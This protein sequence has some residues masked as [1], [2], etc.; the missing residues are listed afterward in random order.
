MH[1]VLERVRGAARER[2]PDAE[3]EPGVLAARVRAALACLEG[4][5]VEARCAADL[6]PA[7]RGLIDG[8]A[9]V[10]VAEDGTGALVIATTDGAV[11]V[12]A[13]LAGLFE[14]RWP[15]LAIDVAR[16]LEEAP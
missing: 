13:S 12:D 2:L 14:R 10:R 3:L 1:A 8:R 7:V 6:A 5:D 4:R 11:E 16:A 9:A 15:E